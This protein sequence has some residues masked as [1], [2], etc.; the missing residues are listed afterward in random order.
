MYLL[1]VL[2]T[3]SKFTNSGT[4][5]HDQMS[6]SSI[7]FTIITTYSNIEPQFCNRKLSCQIFSDSFLPLRHHLQWMKHM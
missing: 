4:G 3:L 6:S 7:T 2:A 1:P 5:T